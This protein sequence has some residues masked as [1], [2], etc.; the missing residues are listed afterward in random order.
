MSRPQ[1]PLDGSRIRVA[2]VVSR[3]NDSVTDKLLDGAEHCL[4]RH[5]CTA[6]RRKVVRV[7][8]AW[9]IPQ[10]AKRLAREG[11]FD[12]IIGLGALIRGE[13]PHFDVLAA[14][15]ARGLGQVGL[16][17]GIPTIF[18][19]LTTDTVE[20]ALARAG[21][22]SRNKGSE[23]ALAALEMAGLFHDIGSA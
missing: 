6:E 7:P 5:G 3:F 9:E 22:N 20:Q 14:E 10:A 11:G 1:A 15:V 18:G 19:V 17:S 13:T 12:V 23:A 2:L 4:E 21:T 16:D 8:G